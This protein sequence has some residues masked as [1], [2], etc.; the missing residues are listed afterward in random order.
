[1]PW[2]IIPSFPTDLRVAR[3]QA[4]A[5]AVAA[6][7]GAEAAVVAVKVA[8]GTVADTVP[9]SPRSDWA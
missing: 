8:A 7:P 3:A 9:I 1:M 5:M 6:A 2:Q 4:A